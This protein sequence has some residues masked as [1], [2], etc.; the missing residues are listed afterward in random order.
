FAAAAVAPGSRPPNAPALPA[1]AKPATGGSSFLDE[2]LAKRGQAAPA[3]AVPASSASLPTTTTIPPPT[4]APG[5]AP[6]APTLASP[7]PQSQPTSV[8]A[9]VLPSAGTAA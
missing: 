3:S 8:P 7:Q 9:T 5:V 2:W 6:G 4:T 1:G